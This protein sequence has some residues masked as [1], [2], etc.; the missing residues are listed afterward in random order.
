MKTTRL[1]FIS[2]VVTSLVLQGC[3]MAGREAVE[4]LSGSDHTQQVQGSDNYTD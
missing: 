3:I 2:V 1:L 4:K